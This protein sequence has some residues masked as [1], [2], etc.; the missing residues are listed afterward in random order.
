[1]NKPYCVHAHWDEEAKV[2]LAPR[3][4]GPGLAAAPDT[5][6]ALV[7]KRKPLIAKLAELNV[8]APAP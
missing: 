2:W 4:D 8:Q 6:G 3:A 5:T 1:M 7:Q